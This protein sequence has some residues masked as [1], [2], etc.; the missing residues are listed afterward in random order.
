[1]HPIRSRSIEK[2]EDK[3]HLICLHLLTNHTDELTLKISRDGPHPVVHLLTVGV[4]ITRE[5]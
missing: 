4:S 1:M 5:L 2:G 3:V